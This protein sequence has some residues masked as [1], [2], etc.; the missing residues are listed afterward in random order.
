MNCVHRS[1]TPEND[2][3][4]L[5]SWLSTSAEEIDVASSVVTVRKRHDGQISSSKKSRTQKL[6]QAQEKIQTAVINFFCSLQS[7]RF[8]RREM[9]CKISEKRCVIQRTEGHAEN[10]V[11]LK[12][13]S[14]SAAKRTIRQCDQAA[15]TNENS[16]VI[17][18]SIF[19]DGKKLWTV[20]CENWRKNCKRKSSLNHANQSVEK[21]EE[22][23]SKIKCH[24]ALWEGH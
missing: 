5:T 4:V 16:I 20:A 18:T 11:T 23:K 12:N 14:E 24:T 3:E 6:H 19:G 13:E 1:Q 22:T 2:G 15:F 17:G 8:Y 7:D 10:S 21:N 9:V